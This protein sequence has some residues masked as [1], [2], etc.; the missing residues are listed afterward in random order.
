LW[1][2][3]DKEYFEAPGIAVIVFQNFYPEG[4]QG[5]IEIIQHGERVATN[6]DLRLEPT[7]GQWAELPKF[8]RREVRPE[9]K[10]IR[11]SMSYRKNDLNY[12]IK[13]SAEDDSI[14]VTV[15]LDKP[16][17][18]RPFI[19]LNIIF[20][21]GEKL[22]AYC[23]YDEKKDGRASSLCYGDQPAMQMTY[24]HSP[25]KLVVSSEKTNLEE[26]WQPLVSGQIIIGQIVNRKIRISMHKI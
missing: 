20:S 21:D 17:E 16:L 18:E 3:N 12:T 2:I 24:I 4:K 19:G 1:R 6:G 13:V 15:D 14:I 22:Y 25:E 9:E 23:K 10:A 11:V 5:G 7:P 8:I 26:N